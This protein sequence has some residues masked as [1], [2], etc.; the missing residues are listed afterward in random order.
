VSGPGRTFA[1]LLCSSWDDDD[2]LERS[3]PAKVMYWSL[4]GQRDISPAGILPLTERRWRRY[5]DGG[6][7]AVTAALDELATHRYIVIDDDTAEV[8]VRSFIRHDGRLEN[9]KLAKSVH[10]AVGDIRSDQL[11][12]ACRR[13]YPDVGPDKAHRRPIEHPSD[14]AR[15]PTTT[16]QHTNPVDNHETPDKRPIEGPSKGDRCTEARSQEPEPRPEAAAA[17]PPHTDPFT[18]Q[19]VDAIIGQRLQNERIHNPTG[20]RA[21]LARELPTEHGHRIQ[22]L[23]HL[24]P[25]AGAQQIAAAVTTGDTRTLAPHARTEPS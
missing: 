17:N 20:W 7:P 3:D 2:F 4:I 24:F 15:T 16:H 18:T 23:H 13:E 5:L 10:R 22:E 1:K 9:S 6:L 21:K 14:A 25:T 11:R 19:V 8:W 12:E